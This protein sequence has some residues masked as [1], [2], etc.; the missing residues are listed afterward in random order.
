MEKI[1]YL[2]LEKSKIRDAVVEIAE[3]KFAQQQQ[4]QS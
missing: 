4:Q 2:G 3:L 1:Q